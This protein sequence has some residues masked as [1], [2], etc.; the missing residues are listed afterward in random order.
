M[1]PGHR[2][3]DEAGRVLERACATSRTRCSRAPTAGC[4]TAKTRSARWPR[5]RSTTSATSSWP[6][7]RDPRVPRVSPSRSP[8]EMNRWARGFFGRTDYRGLAPAARLH[9][10]SIFRRPGPPPRRPSCARRRWHRGSRRPSSTSCSTWS[11]TTR[12][13][14]AARALGRPL[15]AQDPDRRGSGALERLLTALERQLGLARRHDQGLRARRADRGV[16]PA[17]GDPRRARPAFRRVQHGPLGL[18]QQRRR[19]PGVGPGLHES[20]HRRDH[21]DVRLHAPL[22]GPRAAGGEHPRPQRPLCALAGR[23]GAQHS[24]RVRRRASRPG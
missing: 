13:L 12:A 24:G 18:H 1:D 3:G 14:R 23:H 19:R 8:R 9:D 5:C 10:A 11:T 16:L 17:H 20:E 22:R 6:S 2:P 15:P 7:P 4:S 21:D